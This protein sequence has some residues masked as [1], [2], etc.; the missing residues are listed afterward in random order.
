MITDS[1]CFLEE[2]HL[3]HSIR[4]SDGRIEEF[5]LPAANGL[6]FPAADEYGGKHPQ[7]VTNFFN[8]SLTRFVKP[9]DFWN[10]FGGIGSMYRAIT[11]K[12]KR[13]R[14][15]LSNGDSM[16]L[17]GRLTDDIEFVAISS[18]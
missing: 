8:S 13:K 10:V 11:Q 14:K 6:S 5:L 16:K 2:K 17:A 9:E 3:F 1:V 12:V 18:R 4:K 15:G 7:K